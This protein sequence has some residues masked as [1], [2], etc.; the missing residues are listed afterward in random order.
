MWWW[1][2]VLAAT[3]AAPVALVALALWLDEPPR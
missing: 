2:A 3:I 1:L